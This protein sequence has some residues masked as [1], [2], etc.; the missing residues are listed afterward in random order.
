[1][2]HQLLHKTLRPIIAVD[3]SGLTKC[4]E[5][6]F[7]RAAV[8]VG[9]R[10]L[11]LYEQTFHISEYGK[12]KTHKDFMS[13]LRKVIPSDCK[14]IIVSDAGFRNNWFRLVTSCRW[15]FIGRI[16]HN[17]QCKPLIGGE[18]FPIK[19]LYIHASTNAKFIGEVLLAK[20][21]PL[22]CYFHL[23]KQKKKYRI[24]RNLI[25]KKIQCSVSLKHAKRGNEPWLI[26]TSLDAELF[27]AK[28][29]MV[30][31][32]KRMQIEEAFRDLK[33]HRNGF[34]LRQCRSFSKERLNIA[35]LIAALA[36]FLLWIIGIAAKQENL[37]YSFQSNTVR[38]RN[39]LSNYIIGW[40]VLE[41]RIFIY[42][43]QIDNALKEVISCTSI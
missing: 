1:M 5:Y 12:H 31:Y 20:T 43:Y 8:A 24:K 35:L 10:T 34:N 29:V 4:G 37:H 23:I 9:G 2:Y 18:W 28:Q 3:W 42:S 19:N 33:N 6:H 25:G 32:K 39:V 16:R 17:T 36:M 38:N 22:C 30:I 40:Q 15:D 14:P 27:S 41:R 26:A 11:T 21:N 7:L 13:G